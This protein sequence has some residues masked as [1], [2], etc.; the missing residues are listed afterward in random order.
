KGLLDGGEMGGGWG[1]VVDLWW[2]LEALSEFLTSTKSHGTTNRLKAVGTWVE[3][4]HKGTPDIGSTEEMEAQWWAWWKA[5]NPSWCIRDGELQQDGDGSLE[6]LRCPGQNGFLNII[7]CLKWWWSSMETPS[8]MWML[9]LADVK[10][11]LERLV[12]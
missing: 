3:N 10:W 4:T 5:I 1:E 2:R 11:V 8:P 9:V 6:E 7:A 12:G